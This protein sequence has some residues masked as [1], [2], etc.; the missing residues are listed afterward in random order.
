MFV[1][2]FRLPT[3]LTKNL[4]LEIICLK[5]L[6]CL[7]AHATKILKKGMPKMSVPITKCSAHSYT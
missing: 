5:I 6:E 3:R 7:F 2:F 1:P 4:M